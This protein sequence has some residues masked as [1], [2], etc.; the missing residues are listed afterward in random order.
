MQKR[1]VNAIAAAA[2]PTIKGGF[3]RSS[4]PI[5]TAKA[6]PAKRQPTSVTIHNKRPR[7]AQLPI[8]LADVFLP[9]KCGLIVNLQLLPMNLS[10]DSPQA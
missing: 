3:I 9:G 5:Q 2:T 10:R 6:T 1:G 4:S 8:F 7:R